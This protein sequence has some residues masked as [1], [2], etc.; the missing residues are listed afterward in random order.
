M[1]LDGWNESF[2]IFRKMDFIWILVVE[3]G[4]AVML[5]QEIKTTI[6]ADYGLKSTSLAKDKRLDVIQ[7]DAAELPFP[8]CY[9]DSVT[10]LDPLEHIIEPEI[11]LSEISRVLKVGSV[12]LLQIPSSADYRIN[13]IGIWVYLRQASLQTCGTESGSR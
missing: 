9:L 6:A 12:F 8:D 5:V 2:T 11:A 3:V 13:D 4:M 7:L 1:H 10:C